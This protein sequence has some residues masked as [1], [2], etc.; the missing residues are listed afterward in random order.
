MKPPEGYVWIYIFG[1][2]QVTA[3]AAGRYPDVKIG[4]TGGTL[5]NRQEKLEAQRRAANNRNDE[6]VLLAAV[7]GKPGDEGSVH[8]YFAD[9][10]LTGENFTGSERLAGWVNWLRG[11][12]WTTLEVGDPQDCIEPYD[13]WAP[14]A[15][16]V[17]PYVPDPDAATQLVDPG[18]VLEGPLAGT[19]W[20]WMRTASLLVSGDYFTPAEL[21][22]AAR[23]AMGGIDLDPA[24]HYAANR[25]HRVPVFYDQ[26]SN[27]LRAN[28]TWSGRVWMNPPYGNNRPWFLKLQ[29][30]YEAGDIKQA[31]YLAPMWVFITGLAHQTIM[32]HVSA[33]L[34]LTPTPRFWGNPLAK[35]GRND[36]HAIAY[37]GPNPAR[38]RTAFHRYG[39]PLLPYFDPDLPPFEHQTWEELYPTTAERIG[40]VA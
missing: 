24:S 25:I 4:R 28:V 11:G 9:E 39:P 22:V 3:D 32:R 14:A 16:H 20:D 27:G 26:H 37:L 10:R 2:P 21:V 36:P 5:R 33:L 40:A 18:R 17:A 38:F 6:L 12:W 30:H 31:C 1:E 8:A 19:A 13:R 7:L 29:Q 34:L 35:T 15:D 23:A